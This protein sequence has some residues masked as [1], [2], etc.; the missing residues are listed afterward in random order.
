[1]SKREVVSIALLGLN[2]PIVFLGLIDPL[3]GGLALMLAGVVFAAALVIGKVKPPIYLW[4]SYAAALL[5][6][7]LTIVAALTIGREGPSEPMNPTV[8]IGMWVYR[9]A[10]V[11][12]LVSSLVFLV[13]QIRSRRAL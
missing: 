7:I 5:I 13:A 6:G 11:A 12:T 9:F 3:E 1:M 4:V 8:L 2:L 10:V